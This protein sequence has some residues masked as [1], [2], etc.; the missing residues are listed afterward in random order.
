M[1]DMETGR[2]ERESIVCDMERERVL[3]VIWRERERERV[4]CVIWRQGRE[5]ESRKLA[6]NCISQRVFIQAIS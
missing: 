4:L 5:G 3:C 6:Q 1:C 2:V